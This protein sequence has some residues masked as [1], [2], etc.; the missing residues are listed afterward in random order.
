M[1]VI[2]V[3]FFI[4]F[5]Q[6]IFIIFIEAKLGIDGHIRES[7]LSTNLGLLV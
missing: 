7:P 6:K 2:K 4:T 5:S 1:F 3:V